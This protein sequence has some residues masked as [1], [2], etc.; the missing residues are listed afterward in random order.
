MC[1]IL[2]F[3]NN[4]TKLR[5]WFAQQRAFIKDE[6]II[7]PVCMFNM[8]LT[9]R[10]TDVPLFWKALEFNNVER[11]HSSHISQLTYLY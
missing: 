11:K 8:D 2:D 9:D 4:G 6:L 10:Y 7:I 3:I 5:I 1:T